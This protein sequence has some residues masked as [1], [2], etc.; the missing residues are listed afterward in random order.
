MNKFKTTDGNEYFIRIGQKEKKRVYARFGVNIMDFHTDIKVQEK[1]LQPDVYGALITMLVK[2]QLE[3]NGIT[4]K[5]PIEL[6]DNFSD[7]WDSETQLMSQEVLSQA[8]IN[9]HPESQRQILTDLIEMGKAEA[10]AK[11][12]LFNSQLQKQHEERMKLLEKGVSKNNDSS[13]VEKMKTSEDGKTATKL[14]KKSDS[15]TLV[16]QG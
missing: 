5:N 11:L 3:E 9:F 15:T 7:F 13:T 1:L 14:L 4:G 6:E 8:I 16:S 10:K 2:D 12:A